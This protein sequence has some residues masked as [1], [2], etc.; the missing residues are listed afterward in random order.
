MGVRR[1][2]KTG[3]VNERKVKENAGEERKRNGKEN[4]RTWKEK[5][6]CKKQKNKKI[7]K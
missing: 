1:R 4:D 3:R 6:M 7:I 2:K 5:K